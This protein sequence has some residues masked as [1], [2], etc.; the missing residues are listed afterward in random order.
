MANREKGKKKEVLPVE[1]LHPTQ[2]S[3]TG[4]IR[5]TRSISKKNQ[6]SSKLP[7]L[8]QTKNNNTYDTREFFSSS[9]ESTPTHT[10]H[11][12]PTIRPLQIDPNLTPKAPRKTN[13]ELLSFIQSM[14][15]DQSP[16][17]L[18]LPPTLHFNQ[19]L[20]GNPF[21]PEKKDHPSPSKSGNQIETQIN[22]QN[23]LYNTSMHDSTQPPVSPTTS[24]QPIKSTTQHIINQP[25]QYQFWIPFIQVTGN[26]VPEKHQ[27]IRD[28]F[29]NIKGF[30]NATTSRYTPEHFKLTF[31]S[32][33][34]INH[35][36]QKATQNN[37]Q[38]TNT[39]P[40]DTNPLK[41]RSLIMKEIPLG[42]TKDAIR[43][44]VEDF[45]PIEKISW[46]IVGLWQKATITFQDSQSYNQAKSNWSILIG[47]DSTRLVPATNTAQYLQ[48][49]SKY[50]LK[51]TNLPTGT[52]AFD[53]Q[54][55][56]QELGGKTC[57]IPR[58][59]SSYQRQRV[60]YVEFETE[61]ELEIAL[62]DQATFKDQHLIWTETDQTNCIKCGNINHSTKQCPNQPTTR[63]QV[64]N[65]AKYTNLAKL[66]QRK[67]VPI[68]TPIG[69]AGI[70][71]ADLLKPAQT[72]DKD[73]PKPNTNTNN[74]LQVI[75]NNLIN[76]ITKMEVLLETISKA[77]NINFTSNLTNYPQFTFT[78]NHPIIEEN[79][80]TMQQDSPNPPSTQN[81]LKT[82]PATILEKIFQA[83]LSPEATT[84]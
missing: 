14:D 49:R 11:S 30:H 23:S 32:Q 59:A 34:S 3:N 75:I 1:K 64:T 27:T 40:N 15:T 47:K 37:M 67:H 74:F 7:T 2:K 82:K 66:Y 33:N 79:I 51:L 26:T 73:Q 20:L 62:Q 71:W 25:T 76:Q 21:H 56:I 16:K 61:N 35:A 77:L 83:N 38:P 22:H 36:T 44:A 45:G 81:L 31:T 58:I 57:K 13:S 84:K 18:D 41:E 70:R 5:V 50:T 12:S 42:T 80:T 60:A 39:S 65:E 54:D 69:F 43:A 17:I 72:K 68:S 48:E 19:S 53:L 29:A 24:Q 9:T 10:N 78:S 4:A 55:Y 46:S 63:K 52:T 28:T 6:P 8:T